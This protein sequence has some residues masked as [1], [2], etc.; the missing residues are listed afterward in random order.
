MKI[1]IGPYYLAKYGYSEGGK[2]MREHG[3]D[4]LDFDWYANTEN[5]LYRNMGEAFIQ[6]CEMWRDRLTSGGVVINQV[7]GPW[8]YP[9]KDCTENDRAERFE[10]MSRSII[11]AGILGAKYIAIHPIMPFG[12]DS[13]ESPEEQFRMNVDFFSRLVRVAEENNVIICLENMPFV[14]LPTASIHSILR[15]VREVAHPNLKVC[16]DTGHANIVAP[17]PAEAVRLVGKELLMMLHVHDNMGQSDSHFPPALGLGTIDW[18]KFA[19]A[20]AEIE[21]DGVLSLETNANSMTKNED[22]RE[23]KELILAE[24]A[25]WIASLVDSKRARN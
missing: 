21:Y 8:R 10:K 22:E 17:D 6:D 11:A 12:A 9:A 2:R 14:N 23:E 16:L 7:H 1:G 20:L 13:P 4:Y 15:I 18:E 5:E 3:F 25:R 19:E 24:R